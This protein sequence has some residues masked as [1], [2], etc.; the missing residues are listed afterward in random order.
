MIDLCI[1]CHNFQ[2]RLD[3]LLSSILQQN[4][5][6]LSKLKINIAALRGNGNPTTEDLVDFFRH[7]GLNIS[8]LHFD[9]VDVFAKR[10]LV[11][12]RQ[13]DVT[14]SEWL[15]F[16]DADNVYHPDFFKE[17]DVN[18]RKVSRI[19][20]SVNKVH[21]D[22]NSTNSLVDSI[23]YPTIVPSVFEYASSLEFIDK[24]NRKVAGGAMQI[25]MRSVINKNGNGMYVSKSRD[26]HMFKKGQRAYSDK[27]FRNRLGIRTRFLDLPFQIH[28]N[29][30]RDK[31]VG[32]HIEDQR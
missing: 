8:I 29:H 2:R 24:K 31:E 32:Y 16:A 20:T 9:D 23:N 11:R 4:D 6:D 7:Q 3:W 27:H 13:I 12:N 21:T 18:L 28:L 17:L 10:G 30:F 14:E 5:Y 15:F 22:I 1:H 26:H 19:L 25:V